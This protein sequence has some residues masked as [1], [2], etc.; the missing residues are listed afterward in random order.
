M[1]S[2]LNDASDIVQQLNGL[3]PKADVA[4]KAL[5]KLCRDPKYSYICD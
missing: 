3:I 5:E 2:T 1:Q 4:Y